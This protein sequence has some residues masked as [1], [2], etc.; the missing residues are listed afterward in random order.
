MGWLRRRRCGIAD[1]MATPE[2]RRLPD[3][4]VVPIPGYPRW[5]E[6]V[7]RELPTLDPPPGSAPLVRPYVPGPAVGQCERSRPEVT[8]SGQ[9]NCGAQN[10]VVGCGYDPGL[11]LTDV[12]LLLTEKGLAPLISTRE[13]R[14][15]CRACK[16]LLWAIGVVPEYRK[17]GWMS[18]R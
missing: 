5:A 10:G 6:L 4:D 13:L 12:M 7:T 1:P 8:D 15:A 9:D 3:G 14:E 16:R 2:P 11:L 17:N 18:P